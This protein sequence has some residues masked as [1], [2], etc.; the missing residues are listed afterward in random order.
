MG[1][2]IHTV[3]VE[4]PGKSN[5]ANP[6]FRTGWVP[7]KAVPSRR[8]AGPASWARWRRSQPIAAKRLTAVG[9]GATA[10][11]TR[12]ARTP[13]NS[14]R[15]ESRR[16][17]ARWGRLRRDHRAQRGGHVRRVGFRFAGHSRA[18]GGH[19]H[20]ALGGGRPGAEAGGR[21]AVRGPR[22]PD[23]ASGRVGPGA[24]GSPSRRRSSCRSR[25]TAVI[26]VPGWVSDCRPG[27][28]GRGAGGGPR[29]TGWGGL[30]SSVSRF[31]IP[32][33]AWPPSPTR[34]SSPDAARPGRRCARSNT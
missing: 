34:S 8:A 12:N 15:R 4:W 17:P 25:R 13:R 3:R 33:G 21:L 6:P 30:D 31:A 1:R 29:R 10:M 18:G 16:P 27:R 2:A 23:R 28:G 22:Q 9:I 32:M 5:A 24:A 14:R 11:S 26:G 19:R 7:P 20:R